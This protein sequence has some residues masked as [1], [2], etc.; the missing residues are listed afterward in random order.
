M[1][2]MKK[3][4]SLRE[5]S[6]SGHIWARKQTTWLLTNITLLSVSG[7]IVC[8]WLQALLVHSPSQSLEAFCGGLW[9]AERVL[10][11]W[12]LLLAVM[13]SRCCT[14]RC[15]SSPVTDPSR[16]SSSPCNRSNFWYCIMLPVGNIFLLDK[17]VIFCS[18]RLNPSS[19]CCRWPW[20]YEWT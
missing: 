13:H 9:W 4:E 17:S 5:V 19:L 14:C 10:L 12:L 6:C 1:W 20:Q 11:V 3:Q 2:N 15:C 18:W 7:L 16:F 8:W